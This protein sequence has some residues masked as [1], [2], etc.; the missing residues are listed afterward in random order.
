MEQITTQGSD[1]GEEEF[2]DWPV[3]DDDELSKVADQASNAHPTASPATPTKAIKADPLPT[4]SK[5]RYDDMI[6]E[7]GS[8]LR[9][10][11]QTPTTGK[12]DGD[13]FTT[14]ATFNK[15]LF[16]SGT[17][18]SPA[19]TPTPIRYKDGHANQESN[20]TSEILNLLQSFNISIPSEAREALK[21][22]CERHVLYTRGIMKGRDVSRAMV[23]SRDEQVTELQRQIEGLQAERETNR[24]VIRHLRRDIMVRKETAGN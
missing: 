17:L 2:F 15:G 18:P 24:A 13:V 23:R 5:R 16:A 22:T 8:A 21:T 3:S 7:D 6:A 20:L 10:T 4:P 1:S 12:A 9:S 14:P 19:E 11:P